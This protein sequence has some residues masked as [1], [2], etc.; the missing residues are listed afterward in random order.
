LFSSSNRKEFS[1][2][3]KNKRAAKL[4]QRQQQAQTLENTTRAQQAASQ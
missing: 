1:T 2:N 4:A 3:I